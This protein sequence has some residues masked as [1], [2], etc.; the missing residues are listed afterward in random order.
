MKR[1]DIKAGAVYAYKTGTYDPLRPVL[2]LDAAYWRRTGRSFGE[3]DGTEPTFQ[4]HA[5]LTEKYRAIGRDYKPDD[6]FTGGDHHPDCGLLGADFEHSRNRGLSQP[7]LAAQADYAKRLTKVSPA[8]TVDEARALRRP[9]TSLP[10]PGGGLR[11]HL[12]NPAWIVGEWA[13]IVES[14]LAE[15]ERRTN[16][17]DNLAAESADRVARAQ[18][19]VEALRALG[20]PGEVANAYE[21]GHVSWRASSAWDRWRPP[22]YKGNTD[23]VVLS[24]RQVDALLSLIPDGAVWREQDVDEDG[25]TL[26]KPEYDA[27]DAADEDDEDEDVAG[28]VE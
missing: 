19:R 13:E 3:P 4:S 12:L 7:T 15:E 21:Q 14:R 26:R 11:V 23:R 18:K 5:S 28:S 16:V 6:R 24:M 1:A 20:L 9:A 25:W 8:R 22:V 2:V 27:D 10:G 17:E